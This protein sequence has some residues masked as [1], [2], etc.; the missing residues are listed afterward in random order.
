MATDSPYMDDRETRS[1]EERAQQQWATLR[2]ALA[3]AKANSVYWGKVLEEVDPQA[4]QGPSDLARVP[5]TRKSEVPGKQAGNGPFGGMEAASMGQLARVFQ[6]PGPIYE[7]GEDKPDYWRFGR[8]MWAS[9]MRPGHLVHNTFSY[10]L[11]PAGMMVDSGARAI[12]CAVFP[13]GVGNTE[14]QLDAIEQLKPAYYGGTPSFLKILLDKGEELG[15]DTRSFTHALMGGEPFS[16]SLRQ[17]LAERGVRALQCFGTA[18]LGLVAYESEAMEGLITDEDVLVEVVRPGSGEPVPEGEV[19]EMVVTV[20]RE[21]AFPVIRFATGDLTAIMPGVSPCG[22]TAP[23]I[24]G[25]MGRADQRTKVKGMFVA[26][27]QINQLMQRYPEI[28]RARLVVTR[29]NEQDRMT[30]MAEC[31]GTDS[32]LAEKL[33]ESLQG[34]TKLRGQ[35]KLVAPGELPNDGKVIADERSFD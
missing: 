34:V 32:A 1:R 22:R 6:S 10:H 15:R 11:T 13:G 14:I 8:A 4:V 30:L 29:E 28:R 33:T 19:G 12:G 20:L 18:E 17:E 24:R 2:A 25:W 7:G 31:E 9:G 21:G 3:H 27:E 5:L 35:V 23:R 16:N 26:P